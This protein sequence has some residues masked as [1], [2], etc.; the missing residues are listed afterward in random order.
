MKSGL[1][2][3]HLTFKAHKA[4]LGKMKETP[5]RAKDLYYW[6]RIEINSTEPDPEQTLTLETQCRSA[7]QVD[8][9]VMN[10]GDEVSIFEVKLI[11]EGLIGDSTF[12]VGPKQV[13]KY[14]LLYSPV[15]PINSAGAI[16]FD[17][18][19]VGEFW[20]KLKLKATPPDDIYVDPIK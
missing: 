19:T 11:G 1:Y 15:L 9:T 6:Y 14:E 8:I 7:V 10:P 20:Y 18:E 3:G 12:A 4:I 13:V 2:T 17:S 5:E 16:F